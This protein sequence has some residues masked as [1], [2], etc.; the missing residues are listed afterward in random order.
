MKN[1][2]AALMKNE[3]WRC[4]E[5]LATLELLGWNILLFIFPRVGYIAGNE[6][7]II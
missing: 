6:N 4:G 3:K 1:E 7:G 2:A 5:G